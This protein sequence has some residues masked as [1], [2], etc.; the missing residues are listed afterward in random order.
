MATTGTKIGIWMNHSIAHLMEHSNNPFEIK[1]IESNFTHQ[2][3][4]NSLLKGEFHLHKKEQKEQS[5]YYKKLT[6]I[7]K[8]YKEVI[9]F[10]PTNAKEEFFDVITSDNRFVHIK[11]EV[12]QTDLMSPNQQ[13]AFVQE[14][15][16]N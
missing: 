1:T 13:H 12:K 3:K 11:I 5:K 16:E 14:F 4:V 10:G 7:V 9:L 8:R 15:F 6:N 2:E